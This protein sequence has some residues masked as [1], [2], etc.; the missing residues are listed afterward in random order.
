MIR[1][2]WFWLIGII[3]G[4]IMGAV[5]IAFVIDEP[6]RR[7]TE[8]QLNSHLRGYTV[9]IGTLDLHPLRFSVDLYDLTIVQD[10]NPEPPVI[11]IP[12]LNAS[13]HWRALLAA[14]VVSD[15]LVERPNV[16][17]NLKQVRSEATDEVPLKERGWQEAVQAVSPLKINHLQVVEGDVTY[18][19]EGPYQPLRISR[20]HLRAG[21]I[22]NI[23]SQE[24]V[25]PS[26]LSME[27][28]IFDSGKMQLDGEADFLAVP[29]LALKARLLLENM[30]LG[31]VKPIARH[32]NVFL[33]RG[34]LSGTGEI[35]Y[36]PSLKVAHLQK[37]E[38]HGLQMDYIHTAQTAR[39]E[40]KR[41]QEIRRAAEEAHNAPG[42]VL[43]ADR[44]SIVKSD[45]GFVNKAV[46]PDYRL[47]L[48]DLEVNVTNF[49]NQLSEG[50]M[51]TKVTGKF[52]GSGQTTLGATFRPETNGPDFALAA[53]IENTQ[54]RTMNK[55]L[56][57]HGNF[58]VVRG[59]FSLYTEFR[60]K[61]G[62]V[63]GYVKPLFKD[64]DVYDARQ[65]REKSLFQKIY[66]GLVG[67][68]SELLENVPRDEVA[69]KAEISGRLENPQASTWQV[70]VNL[71]QNAFF[72]SILPGYENELGRPRR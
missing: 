46:N 48:T 67:G 60:V 54:M 49:S 23:R 61:N 30:D 53:S 6:L 1:R 51:I 10:A 36:T 66:E 11:H 38:V 63:R 18:V 50:T 28:V 52:M 26:D 34:S 32:Y 59:F 19:D 55:L 22:R 2:R 44:V 13:V 12:R 3:A 9:R 5:A 33:Q 72:K 65:D 35:E 4:L 62:A 21:N 58:D 56:R 31:Y 15:V 43:K 41:A 57:A 64:M 14:R 37:A 45:L 25:Y 20:L 39:V 24:G 27:G 68:V 8:R 40:R 7:Y 71:I 42:L 29:H 47:F 16:H 17:I 69:T 70:L